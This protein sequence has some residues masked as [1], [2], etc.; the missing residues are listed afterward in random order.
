MYAPNRRKSTYKGPEVE[1]CL[2]SGNK[3]EASMAGAEGPRGRTQEDEVRDVR[4]GC[5]L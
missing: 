3:E 5:W 4:A 2:H 1:A